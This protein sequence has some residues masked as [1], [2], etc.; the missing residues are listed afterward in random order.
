MKTLLEMHFIDNDIEGKREVPAFAIDVG[1]R[2]G[3]GESPGSAQAHTGEGLVLSEKFC[4]IMLLVV[5]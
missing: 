1:K 3:V 5:S 4:S 2:K